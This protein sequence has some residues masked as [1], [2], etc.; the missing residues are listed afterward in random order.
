MTADKTGTTK[1]GLQTREKIFQAALEL[2]KERGYEQTTLVDICRAAGI[3]SGTF[4]HHFAS[5]QDI[6]IEFVKE[7]SLDLRNYYESLPKES[8]A[9]VFMQVMDYQAL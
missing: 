9:Q 7:E 4:Y 3:A 2:I 1:K 8:Y 6:L 5:K